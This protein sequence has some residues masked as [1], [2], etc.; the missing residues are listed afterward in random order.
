MS[1]AITAAKVNIFTAFTKPP[2]LISE[3][4][5]SRKSP[6]AYSPIIGYGTLSTGS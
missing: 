6:M 4:A 5:A 3:P 1:A 2:D